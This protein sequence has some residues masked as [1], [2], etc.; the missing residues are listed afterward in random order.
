MSH[1]RDNLL[2]GLLLPFLVSCTTQF[3]A[4]IQHAVLQVHPIA[5]HQFFYFV[6]RR[7][8]A[9]LHFGSEV[10]DIGLSP[11]RKKFLESKARLISDKVPFAFSVGKYVV[12]TEC[13]D[14]YRLRSAPV[15][16]GQS[17]KLTL[18]CNKT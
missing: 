17:N 9:T 13:T 4:P 15:M 2:L 8:E 14:F 5:D 18:D 16:A 11:E 1:L 3:G 10:G 7:D 6:I 12:V